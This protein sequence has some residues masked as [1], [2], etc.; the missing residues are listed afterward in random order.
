MLRNGIP[1][2]LLLPFLFVSQSFAQVESSTP[3]PVL[4]SSRTGLPS[5]MVFVSISAGRFQMG[6]PSSEGAGESDESLHG[7]YVDGFELM[8]TEVT[9]GMWEEIMGTGNDSRRDPADSDWSLSGEGSSYPAYDVSWD[10]CQEFINRLNDLDSSHNYRLPTEAEW[11]Y[12]C[13]ADTSSAYYWG[14]ST[15]ERT[16][17]QYCW[18]YKNARN[19]TWTT[20]HA[21]NNG[22]QPVGLKQPNAWG[23]YDMSGNV[24]EWCQDVY[25]SDYSNCPV[26]GSAY[27]GQGLHRVVRGGSWLNNAMYCRSAKRSSRR[28]GFRCDFIGF[29]LAR[30]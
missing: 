5:G 28:P 23:L 18:Y 19:D 15:S 1:V 9:Q 17:K 16:M 13:R 30:S 20:P 26:D 27:T 8:S 2:Y 29:R 11:E 25:T 4:S 14:S 6:S 7:V 21:A 12:A 24:L 3:S 10:D 22:T